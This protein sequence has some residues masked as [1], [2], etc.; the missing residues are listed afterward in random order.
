VLDATPTREEIE[1]GD[2]YGQWRQDEY[3]VH[4]VHP[5]VGLPSAESGYVLITE[6]GSG[7]AFDPPRTA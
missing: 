1:D 7:P 5:G 3:C 4:R 6:V 2:D